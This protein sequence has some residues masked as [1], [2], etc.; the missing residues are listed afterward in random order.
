MTIYI[1]Q[2][3]YTTAAIN[4]QGPP[5]PAPGPDEPR[6]RDRQRRGRRTAQ[7]DPPAGDQRRGGADGGALPARRRLARLGAAAAGD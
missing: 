5:D 4:A 3:R 6:R 1:S 7:R 2:G